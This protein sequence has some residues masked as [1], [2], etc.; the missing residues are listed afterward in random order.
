M[1][2]QAKSVIIEGLAE[3]F[4]THDYF[5]VVDAIGL[6]VEETNDFRRKCSQAGVTY[7]VAKNTLIAKALQQIKNEV[8]YTPFTHQVLRGFSGVLFVQ[9]TASIPA[10]I[11]QDFR[12]R[13]KLNRPILKGASIDG[14]L[15]IGEEHLELLSKLKSKAELIGEIITL[16]KSP[17]T[18][19]I[20]ALHSSKDKLAGI[21]KAL[22]AR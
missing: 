17:I 13:K 15:F 11:V 19:V 3:Q 16:L 22:A 6:S 20:A 7:Q 9:E 14:D 18:N 5:Y 2:R 4:R 1:T 10:K 12:Q 8:D 21:I